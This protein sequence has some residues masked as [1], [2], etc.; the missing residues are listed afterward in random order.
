MKVT[1]IQSLF[2]SH[3]TYSFPTP[4]SSGYTNS[5]TALQRRNY[6]SFSN[7]LNRK[8]KLKTLLILCKIFKR[9]VTLSEDL[10]GPKYFWVSFRGE[11]VRF[12]EF[13][14]MYIMYLNG[15]LVLHIV[16]ERKG[17]L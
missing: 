3:L 5:N 11:N 13:I 14:L 16:G 1:I 17:S 8:K 12:N 2:S 6:A 10:D 4:S 15:K 7:E 9:S